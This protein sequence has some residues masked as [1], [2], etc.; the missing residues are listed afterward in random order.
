MHNLRKVGRNP[1]NKL[2]SKKRARIGKY[3]TEYG[4]VSA[5]ADIPHI[6]GIP[7]N[8]K[9]KTG[10]IFMGFCTF[11]SVSKMSRGTD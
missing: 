4:V 2:S 10:F 6:S 1:H 9:H 7:I 11:C 8:L 5:A 3:A